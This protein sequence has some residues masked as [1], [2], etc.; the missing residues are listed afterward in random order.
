MADATIN[1]GNVV[2]PPG[3]GMESVSLA[4]DEAAR[5]LGFE[6]ERTSGGD[7]ATASATIPQDF[8]AETLNAGETP[9]SVEE[10]FP[11]AIHRAALDI[12]TLN[13]WRSVVPAGETARAWALA[14][15]IQRRWTQRQERNAGVTLKS[16]WSVDVS[17]TWHIFPGGSFLLFGA[18]THTAALA[19]N[20]E[21]EAATVATPAGCTID[22]L[23]A[24]PA[25]AMNWCLLK[26]DG[27]LVF[28]CA[29]ASDANS[30]EVVRVMGVF[31]NWNY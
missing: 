6:A 24:G 9:G 16:G 28:R 19:A 20:S 1:L 2:G 8:V 18:L 14:A 11:A 3:D 27:T 15:R 4:F 22:S 7:P 23:C 10:A 29:K 12:D 17:L 30:S 25:T 5:T 21:T 13:L 31:S 26:G